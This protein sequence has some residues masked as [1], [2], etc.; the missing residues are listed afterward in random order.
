LPCLYSPFL[1]IF[2]SLSSFVRGP[3]H[4]VLGYVVCAIIRKTFVP[5]WLETGVEMNLPNDKI[6]V[7][8]CKKLVTKY[9]IASS[10]GRFKKRVELFHLL[11]CF[12]R[13]HKKYRSIEPHEPGDFLVR[14]EVGTHLFEVVTIFGNKDVYQSVEAYFE[15]LFQHGRPKSDRIHLITNF[16]ENMGQLKELLVTKLWQKN[17]KEYFKSNQFKTANL[18]LVTAE[19]SRKKE[20]FPWFLPLAHQELNKIASKKNF[21]RCY[22]LDYLPS[23]AAVFDL[24]QILASYKKY[25]EGE[26]WNFES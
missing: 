24:D 13:L 1:V 7:E 4:L 16:E 22:V 26:K 5:I 9:H 3:A 25:L 2:C 21:T 17:E 6:I 8:Q 19:F 20:R 14:D 10:A 23:N 15:N 12:D 11:V 18:L